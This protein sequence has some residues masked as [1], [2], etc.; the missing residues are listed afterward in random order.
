MYISPLRTKLHW[1]PIKSRIIYK[2]SFTIHLATHD[3]TLDYLANLLTPNIP[4]YEQSK[5]NKF[6]LKTPVL[7]YLTSSRYKY[8]SVQKSGMTYHTISD[9]LTQL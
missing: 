9:Q 4:I 7:S 2:M 5:T 6:K 3:N 1:L 8:F